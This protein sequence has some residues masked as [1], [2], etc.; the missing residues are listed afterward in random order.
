MSHL[1][2]IPQVGHFWNLFGRGGRGQTGQHHQTVEASK[3]AAAKSDT[4]NSWSRKPN[5]TLLGFIY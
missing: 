5:T 1:W 3:N 4:I 2:D